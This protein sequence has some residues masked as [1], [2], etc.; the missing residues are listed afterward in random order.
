MDKVLLKLKG[1]SSKELSDWSHKFK[2]WIDTKD[3][4]YISYSYSKD[5]ELNENW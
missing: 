1:K 5:F 2:G 3:G 4:E